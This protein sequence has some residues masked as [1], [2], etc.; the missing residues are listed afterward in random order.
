[1]PE[2]ITKRGEGMIIDTIEYK[3][4][5]IEIIAD[6]DAESPRDWDNLGHM[7]CFYR[8][9]NLG[10]KHDMDK[11]DLKEL[12]KRKDVI[13]LPL[14]L[15]DHSGLWMSTGRFA[16]DSGGWDTSFVGYIYIT[17]EEIKKEMARPKRMKKGQKNPDLQA[18]KRVTKKDI[19]RAIRYLQDEVK[20][21]NDYLTG[22]VV[23]WSTDNDSCWG[24]YG[25]EG[26]KEAIAEGK[27]AIDWQVD[28]EEQEERIADDLKNAV[29]SW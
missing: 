19:E 8:D 17:H 20:T 9:Y 18:I 2:R 10:D 15:L 13:A 16:C 21:Y 1:M 3:G 23:G 27:Q 26:L 29:G 6:E 24:Y 22:A 28:M 4:H 11:E 12:V 25:D 14:F 7:I 5:E